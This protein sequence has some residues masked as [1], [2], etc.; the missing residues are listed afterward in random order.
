MR[1]GLASRIRRRE[2]TRCRVRVL[3]RRER[4]GC[5]L[6]GGGWVLAQVGL[7]GRRCLVGGGRGEVCVVGIGAGCHGDVLGAD[8]REP[9]DGDGAG[10]QEQDAKPAEQGDGL[11]VAPQWLGSGGHDRYAGADG[12][13][14]YVGDEAAAGHEPGTAKRAEQASC[15][16]YAAVAGQDDEHPADQRGPAGNDRVIQAAG[17]VVPGRIRREA[18]V[19]VRPDKRREPAPESQQDKYYSADTAATARNL[20]LTV[21]VSSLSP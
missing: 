3:R 16:A 5:A 14:E 18:E 21:H 19:E 17:V 9:A 20:T 12:F 1:P 2:M 4:L 15:D 11:Q 7:T 10:H 8:H 6:A 13:L